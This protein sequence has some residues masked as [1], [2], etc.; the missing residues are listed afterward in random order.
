MLGWTPLQQRGRIVQ[1]SR[2]GVRVRLTDY[3]AGPKA[4]I[5]VA[6]GISACGPSPEAAVY[7]LRERAERAL[8]A[9]R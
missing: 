7:K 1:W 4:W 3:G 6:P 8:E 2:G 9:T 5:A